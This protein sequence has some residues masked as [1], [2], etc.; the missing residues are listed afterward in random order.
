MAEIPKKTEIGRSFLLF[1]CSWFCAAI[2]EL[3]AI[4][5]LTMIPWVCLDS[6]PTHDLVDD[7]ATPV[8]PAHGRKKQLTRV[9]LLDVAHA[10]NKTVALKAC[11]HLILANHAWEQ[12]QTCR[13][14]LVEYSIC[15]ICIASFNLLIGR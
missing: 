4:L 8:S 6:T 9:H 12:K 1:Q 14:F 10:P 11:A 15:P 7:F 3:A 5:S 2:A 13:V